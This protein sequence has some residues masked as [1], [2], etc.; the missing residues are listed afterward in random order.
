[1]RPISRSQPRPRAFQVS[2]SSGVT[3]ATITVTAAPAAFV[4][5]LGTSVASLDH[6]FGSAVNQPIPVRVL[7]SNPDPDQRGTVV[8]VPGIL[9]DIMADQAH[10][11]FYIMRQDRNQVLVYDGTTNAFNLITRSAYHRDDANVGMA[12]APD[13]YSER[14]GQV[15][16]GGQR[17][18]PTIL[19]C[20]TWTR[21]RRALP[22]VLPGSD[23]GRSVAVA[24][25]AILAFAVDKKN[26]V[27]DVVRAQPGHRARDLACQPSGPGRT[28]MAGSPRTRC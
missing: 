16:S 7:V 3:P 18:F 27:G 21:C 1:M 6:H 26:I 2:P 5:A 12:I 4:G 24:N 23:F 10:N 15:P 20:S 28:T 13:P 22:V 19:A 11:R 8:N 9:S 14:G 25:N 17:R